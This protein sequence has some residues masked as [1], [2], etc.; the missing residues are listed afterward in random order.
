[1]AI[2]DLVG[3]VRIDDSDLG[4][5]RQSLGQFQRGLGDTAKPVGALDRSLKAMGTSVGELGT[6]LSIGVTLPIVAGLGYATK[7]ASDL[8]EAT[9]ATGV[10]FGDARGQVDDFVA[11]TASGLG[12]SERAAREATT[13]FGGLLQNMGFTADEAARASIDLTKLASDMGS[14]FNREPAEAV[15][16]LGSALRGETEPIRAFNVTLD[17]A[18]IRQKAVS[19]GLAET[20]AEVDKNGKAQATLAL[21]TEQTAKVQG[22]FAN[23]SDGLANQTRIMRAELEDTAAQLGAELLP[24][25][26]EVVSVFR[27]VVGVLADLPGPAQVALLSILG[28]AAGV[29]PLLKLKDSIDRVRAGLVA[30]R[31]SSAASTLSLGSLGGALAPLIPFLVAGGA[32]LFAWHKEKQEAKKAT[33]E[34]TT[35]LEADS[36]ALGENSQALILNKLQRA[37]QLDDLARAGVSIDEVAAA[38]DN[39]TGARER[40]IRKLQ[41]EGEANFGL[42][43]NLDE[44][45]DAADA[46]KQ[47][48]E[49]KAKVTGESADADIGAADAGREF[50]ESL[51][52]GTEAADEQRQALEELGD[53]IDTFRG[54]VFGVAE[55][56]LDYADAQDRVR[57]AGGRVLEATLALDEALA[58]HGRA[59]HEGQA[60]TD[61][62]SRAQ[63]DLLRA[64]L[65]GVSSA[66]ELKTALESEYLATR[67]SSAESRALRDRLVALAAQFPELSNVIQPYIDKLGNIPEDVKTTVTVDAFGA[68]QAI[69]KV[70]LALGGVANAVNLGSLT[71]KGRQHGG[72]VTA[73]VPYVVGEKRPELF[74]PRVDGYIHPTV[75]ASIGPGGQTSTI[76]Q[77]INVT[78]PLDAHRI[79]HVAGHELAWQMK[80]CGR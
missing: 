2:P 68:L 77:T 78:A 80:T 18:T 4:R 45:F 32:A 44:L 46:S 52:E 15:Q 59:S 22:D 1:M 38:V 73:G 34:F 16:A 28:L 75:P 10:I 13:S 70:R 54:V 31:A 64:Q 39:E 7:A 27:D 42:I 57:D 76:Q 23:T 8:G 12:Q 14:A 65:D 66:D 35:A 43:N 26:L 72:P 63:R 25:A 53:R 69:D 67:Q 20:T 41:E 29:G 49:D 24:I 5:A 3:R 19:L 55:A 21:I 50:V 30:L 60:A 79:A 51:N 11:T 9:N 74:V 37:D 56:Q 17:D 48:L 47:V 33:E 71:F 61:E 36:G 40:L 62:L 6:K 58:N